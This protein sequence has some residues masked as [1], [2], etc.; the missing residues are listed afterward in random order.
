MTDAPIDLPDA[1]GLI[2]AARAA[3]LAEI[4]P[5]LRDDQRLTGLMIASALAIAA[6]E[7]RL[8]PEGILDPW[9]LVHAL[10]AGTRDGDTALYQRLLADA[11]ARVAIANPRYRDEQGASSQGS[12]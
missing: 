9:P 5:M 4:Q 2:E 11:E 7:L 3:F 12:R 8:P 1:A 10:R 6:R